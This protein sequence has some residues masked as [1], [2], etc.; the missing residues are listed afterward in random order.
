MLKLDKSWDKN[1]SVKL[2]RLYIDIIKCLK[3]SNTSDEA[4]YEIQ[5]LGLENPIEWRHWAH[6]QYYNY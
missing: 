4:L 1:T 3:Y 2:Y 5:E 6:K